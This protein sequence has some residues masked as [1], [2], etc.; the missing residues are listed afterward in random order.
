MGTRRRLGRQGLG[1]QASRL[2]TAQSVPG[3]GALPDRAAPPG[4][5]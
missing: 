2:P 4:G 1:E 5:G 3:H